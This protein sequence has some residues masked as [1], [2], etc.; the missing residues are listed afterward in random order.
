MQAVAAVVTGLPAVPASR[1]SHG[2]TGLSLVILTYR[3]L[4]VA[5]KG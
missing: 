4:R 5:A 3:V 2:L 1:V